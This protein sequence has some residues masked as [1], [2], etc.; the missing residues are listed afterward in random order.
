[1]LAIV[2]LVSAK[3]D[4]PEEAKKQADEKPRLDDKKG[5]VWP[6]PDVYSEGDLMLHGSISFERVRALHKVKLEEEADKMILAHGR[7]FLR[8]VSKYFDD[9]T[10]FKIMPIL[11]RDSRNLNSTFNRWRIE[12]P[13]VQATPAIETKETVQRD[14]PLPKDSNFTLSN[15]TVETTTSEKPSTEHPLSTEKFF[16]TD[17]PLSTTEKPFLS[18]S[19][20][21]PEIDIKPNQEKDK[22]TYEFRRREF[23]RLVGNNFARLLM[24]EYRKES[25]IL[26][27]TEYL[28]RWIADEA[29]HYGAMAIYCNENENVKEI[30]KQ[31][32]VFLEE[33]A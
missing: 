32:V 22:D 11:C 18:S 1:L 20:V 28:A 21:K 15:E 17:K 2:A 6:M 31:L 12:F 5:L 4:K 9:N 3:E 25:L 16:S 13:K 19:S 29:V 24:K 10:D 30:K 26:E 14:S 7:L 33:K 27:E 8:R 23:Y